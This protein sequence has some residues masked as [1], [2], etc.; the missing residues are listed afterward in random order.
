MAFCNTYERDIHFAK[1]GTEFGVADAIQ[2]E[3]L[4]DRFAFGAKGPNTQDCIRPTGTDGIR[5]DFATH[6]FSV[7]YLVPQPPCLRTFYVVRG[8]TIAK[9]GNEAG[10]FRYECSRINL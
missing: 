4:A 3:R 8:K 9:Q 5:F 2:Y 1:H 6:Y 10:Y 7:C